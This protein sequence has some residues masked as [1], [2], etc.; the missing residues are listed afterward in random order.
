MQGEVRRGESEATALGEG[1]N[2][3]TQNRGAA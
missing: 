1:A 2:Q 3:P